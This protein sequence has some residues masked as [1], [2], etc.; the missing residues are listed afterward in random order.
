VP[1]CLCDKPFLFEIF[2]A[3]KLLYLLSFIRKLNTFEQH[4]ISNKSYFNP[5]MKK[6][7][8][9]LQSVLFSLSC[10][11]QAEVKIKNDLAAFNMNGNVR[12]VTQNYFQVLQTDAGKDSVGQQW[13]TTDRNFV[14]NYNDKGFIAWA[15]Y[16]KTGSTLD[17]R[18]VYKYDAG[19]NRI[20]E[21]W[22]DSDNALD[23]RL[24]RKFSNKG[25]MVELKK[26]TDTTGECDEKTVYE[27]DPTGHPTK[28]TLYDGS[29]VLINTTT[30]V[31]DQYGHKT[32]ED[33]LNTKGKLMEKILFVFDTKGNE[34]EEDAYNGDGSLKTKKKFHYGY[35]GNI[36]DQ[37]NYDNNGK[38]VE[39][40]A[41]LYN[42]Q[43]NETGYTNTDRSGIIL[44]QY[45]YTYEYDD[46]GNWI[47]KT[48]LTNGKAEYMCTREIKY[49]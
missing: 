20:E 48:E 25:F 15:N 17:Y 45:T 22:F 46:K 28:S 21:T 2:L 37:E 12:S 24:T 36:A 13:E 16:Y 39:K 6:I 43:G 10:L 30:Y 38:L 11:A 40:F 49:Y 5:I 31:Y 3:G 47:K 33:M 42:D 8:L 41:Y 27:V 34:S 23:Y 4:T 19:G 29:D 26:Y 32:E 44:Y 7:I 35:M 18:Y 14:I 1:P 9:L